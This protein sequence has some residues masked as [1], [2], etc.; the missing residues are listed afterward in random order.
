MEDKATVVAE[1]ADKLLCVKPMDDGDIALG[2]L[3]KASPTV[4]AK[5]CGIRLNKR[6]LGEVWRLL[7]ELE[8]Q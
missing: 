7:K 3:N 2:I 5:Q 6:Q 1:T 4:L 8:E